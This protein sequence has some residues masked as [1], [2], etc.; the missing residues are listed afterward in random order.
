MYSTYGAAEPIQIQPLPTKEELINRRQ[1]AGGTA[2]A[3][4]DDWGDTPSGYQQPQQR[5]G[6]GN[7]NFYGY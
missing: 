7:Q 2:P 1:V 5:T 6:V 3:A 4:T